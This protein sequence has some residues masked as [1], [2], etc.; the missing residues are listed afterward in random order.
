MRKVCPTWNWWV[1]KF[2]VA[3]LASYTNKEVSIPELQ[4]LGPKYIYYFFF[5]PRVLSE[6]SV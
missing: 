6:E 1:F 5:F 2:C 3:Y 4:A